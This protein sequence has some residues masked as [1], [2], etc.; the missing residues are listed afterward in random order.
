MY[1]D[2]NRSEIFSRIFMINKSFTKARFIEG[3]AIIS[4]ILLKM[5]I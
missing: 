4:V 3:I 1:M 5:N 2:Y